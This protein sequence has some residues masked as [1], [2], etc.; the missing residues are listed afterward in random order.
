MKT[1]NTPARLTMWMVVIF[2]INPDFQIIIYAEAQNSNCI[3]IQ[4]GVYD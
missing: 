1:L 4:I 2:L 3:E